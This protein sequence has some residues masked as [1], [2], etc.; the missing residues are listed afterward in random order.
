MDNLVWVIV[1]GA[2]LYASW[3]GWNA[4]KGA[5]NCGCSDG[6]SGCNG[7]SGGKCSDTK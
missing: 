5:G 7:C 1:G 2:L 6:Q 3:R 4:I